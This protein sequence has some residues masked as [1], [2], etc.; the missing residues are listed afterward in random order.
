[1]SAICPYPEPDQ[2]NSCLPSHYRNIHLN[3]ILPSTTRSSNWSLSLRFPHQNRVYTHTFCVPHPSHSSRF[4]HSNNIRWGI[5]ILS[6]PLHNAWYLLLKR[7][8][9]WQQCEI[10]RWRQQ[11]RYVAKVKEALYRPWG[12]QE[13]EAPRVP[14]NRHMKV[15]R[16]SALRTGRLYAPAQE[17]F[18]VLISITCAFCNKN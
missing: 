2:S 12:F 14:D 16:L 9:K 1:M 8:L 15:V 10:M 11:Y 17:M 3:I 13:V 5:Q 6:L 18:L 7:K 4:D